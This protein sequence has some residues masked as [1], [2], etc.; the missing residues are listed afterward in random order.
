MRFVQDQNGVG[1]QHPQKLSSQ[2]FLFTHRLQ[3]TVGRKNSVVTAQTTRAHHRQH[4]FLLLRRFSGFQNATICQGNL[5]IGVCDQGIKLAQPNVGQIPHHVSV[6]RSVLGD[7]KQHFALLEGI[8]HD[9]GT[10]A[11]LADARL[12]TGDKACSPLN[13]ADRGANGWINDAGGLPRIR[14]ATS[15]GSESSEMAFGGDD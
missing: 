14:C 13:I 12:V 11:S 3:L 1:S 10:N 6:E 15:E 2:G 5:R 9:T 7:K 4:F 8:A